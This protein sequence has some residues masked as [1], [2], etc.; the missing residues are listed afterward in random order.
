MNKTID[1][2]VKTKRSKE[3]DKIEEMK[4]KNIIEVAVRKQAPEW[5]KELIPAE[6]QY[7]ARS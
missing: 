6:Y 2:L 7:T 5:L 4:L 1:K 3:V